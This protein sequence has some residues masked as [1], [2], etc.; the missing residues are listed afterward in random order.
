MN[1]NGALAAVFETVRAMHKK[2]ANELEL[3][4]GSENDLAKACVQRRDEDAEKFISEEIRAR[5]GRGFGVD[6]EEVIALQ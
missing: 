4:L 1:Q 2:Y 6:P 5:A 3:A